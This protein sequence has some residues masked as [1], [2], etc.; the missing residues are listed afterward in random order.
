MTNWCI[1]PRLISGILDDAYALCEACE[2]S[3][4]SLL[5]LMDV[6]RKEV[7]YIVLTNLIN[8]RINFCIYVG[9]YQLHQLFMVASPFVLYIQ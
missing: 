6:Y 7:D 1:T 3:L 5:S 2:Q 9:D 8:V 4:S